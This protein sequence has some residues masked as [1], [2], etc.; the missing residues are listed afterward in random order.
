LYHAVGS[1]WIVEVAQYFAFFTIVT[2]F[3]AVA[4]SFVDFLA[5]GL[6][7]KKKSLGK[8]GL[9]LLSLAPP[10]IFSLIYPGIFLT[11]L[12][13]AGAFGAVILFGIL[14]AAMVWSNRYVK[15]VKHEPLLPG[16]KGILGLIIL[17]STVVI[18]LQIIHSI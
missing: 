4:L 15:K 5:D 1:S 14:P 13:Y 10:F 6:N 8:I 7:I 2:S 17:I 12:N 11:A 3:L 9:C 18:L 16:G